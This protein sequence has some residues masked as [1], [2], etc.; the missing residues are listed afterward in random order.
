MIIIRLFET[1]GPLA[2]VFYFF[3]LMKNIFYLLVIVLLHTQCTYE[4]AEPAFDCTNSGL[5]LEILENG[6]ANCGQ[7]DGSL[8]LGASGGEAP[9]TY[10]MKDEAPQQSDTFTGLSAGSYTFLLTDSKGCEA[11]LTTNI[12]NTDGVTISSVDVVDSGCGQ[13]QG[14]ITINAESGTPPYQYKVEGAAFQQDKKLSGLGNG[15]HTVLVK[16]SNDCEFTQNVSISSGISY[17]T[18]ISNIISTNCA[19]S[20]C[21]NGSQFPDFRSFSNIQSNAA[22]I[23]IRTGNKSMPQGRTLT[24]AQIDMIACWVD[25]G[26]INN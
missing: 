10:Q 13:N 3:M 14:A 4:K 21:H 9:Y 8:S 1:P 11:T 12:N 18:D 20:G 2:W 17:S 7:A 15:E 23:K 26:A 5:T 24:Q 25:D 16:D 6:D 22:N 19:I